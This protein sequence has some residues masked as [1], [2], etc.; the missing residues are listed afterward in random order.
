MGEHDD[1]LDAAPGGRASDDAARIADAIVLA[2]ERLAR[3]I[4]HGLAD[5]ADALRER[6]RAAHRR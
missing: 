3:A 1:E 2:C 6:P 4:E 5:V